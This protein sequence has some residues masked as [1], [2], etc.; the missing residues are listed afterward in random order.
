MAYIHAQSGEYPLSSKDILRR[1]PDTCF[2][3]EVE[4]FEAV[5]PCHG[6]AVVQPEPQPQ[7][8]HT[9]NVTEGQPELIEDV[10]Y[11]TWVVT[12]ASSEEVTVRTQ[13]QAAAVR[14]QRTDLL[15]G[16]DWTQ[17]EDAPVDKVAWSFYRQLL[18]DITEQAGFP[19]EVV[20]PDT[21]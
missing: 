21:P 1:H 6:Y 7:T 18:R 10:Y 11:Q 8:D 19:W 16:S 2:P 3:A 12:D 17:L 14:S 20:W 5:L 15:A 13:Q 9:L 4:P